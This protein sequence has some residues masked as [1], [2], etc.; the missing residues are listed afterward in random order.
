MNL[1]KSGAGAI[2]GHEA[3]YLEAYRDPVGIWTIGAGHTKAAG[4]IAPRAGMVLTLDRALQIFADDMV[5]FEARVSRAVRPDVLTTQ[6]RYDALVSFDFN[7]GAIDRGS[8]DDKLNRGDIAG[9][10]TTLQAYVNASGRRLAG[11]VTRR[12]EEAEMFR[13]GRYPARKILLKDR[14]GSQGRYIDPAN[15]PWG[16]LPGAVGTPSFDISPPIAPPLPTRRPRQNFIIDLFNFI[17][18][19]WRRQSA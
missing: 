13:F 17:A 8:V 11:L 7:T 12:R 15:I 6:P 18:N 10:M 19:L 16:D 14:A 1:S 2:L 5:K 9:A 4:G 3:I